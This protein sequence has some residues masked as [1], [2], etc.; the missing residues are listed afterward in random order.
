M[1]LLQY[2]EIKKQYD[3]AETAW[4]FAASCSALAWSCFD[5]NPGISG[6]RKHPH[7]CLQPASILSQWYCLLRRDYLVLKLTTIP[8]LL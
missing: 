8:L 1:R 3:F 4:Q 5:P 6:I 7:F 2:L